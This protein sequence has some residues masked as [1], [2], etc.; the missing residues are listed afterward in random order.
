MMTA[1]EIFA[2]L[3]AAF[4]FNDAESWDNSGYLVHTTRPIHKVLVALD[5]GRAVL[6]EADACGAEL[7]I[8]HHPVIFHPLHTLRPASPAETALRRNIGILSVHTNFDVGPLSADAC[9]SKSLQERLGFVE[10]AVLDVTRP[11][12]TPHG[13]GRIGRFPSPVSF[14]TLLSTM[15]DIF[16]TDRLRAVS[17]NDRPIHS[18]SF[19]S[20]GGGEYLQQVVERGLDAYLTADLKH[21]AFVTAENTG[22][23]LFCPTHYQMEKPAMS[24][25]ADFLRQKLPKLT[26]LESVREEEPGRFF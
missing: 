22:V 14:D 15:K 25:L 20:G 12:P 18:L 1:A 19:C 10:T 5:A 8:T 6:E 21:D 16:K 13:F 9:L 17:G 3:D 7:I 4:P 2:C 23:S 11:L 24:A 26:V